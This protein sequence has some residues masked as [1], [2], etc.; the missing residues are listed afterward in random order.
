MSAWIVSKA[1]IDVLV[2]GVLEQGGFQ[3]RGKFISVV[4]DDDVY[5]GEAECI[6]ATELG[7]LL[8]RENHKS[9]NYRYGTRE[10][11]PS[12]VYR[13]P[14]KHQ[15]TSKTWGSTKY[16]D[17]QTRVDSGVLAKQ[18]AC[19]DYQTCEHQ[20]Y[21]RSRAYSVVCALSRAL[22]SKVEGYE[23]APWGV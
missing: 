1:H 20:T 5:D 18:V 11:T 23:D 19:Y 3:H 10:R 14:E 6:D 9:I 16:L 21:Y 8:W 12:Y 15:T 17:E 7:E 22:V 13:A 2:A 4:G